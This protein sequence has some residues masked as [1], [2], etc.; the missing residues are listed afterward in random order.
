MVAGVYA[1]LGVVYDDL[2]RTRDAMPIWERCLGLLAALDPTSMTMYALP[3]V[4]RK[5]LYGLL[6]SPWVVSQLQSYIR[7]LHFGARTRDALC[8]AREPLLVMQNALLAV[9]AAAS[10]LLGLP[11]VRARRH[12]LKSATRGGA[13]PVCALLKCRVGTRGV[14]GRTWTSRRRPGRRRRRPRRC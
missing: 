14:A 6:L 10:D 7:D 9:L 8:R 11:R 3:D 13:D 4:I 2:M 1:I 5:R 12:V